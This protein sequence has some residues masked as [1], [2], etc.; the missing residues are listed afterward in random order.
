[1]N[2]AITKRRKGADGRR[3]VAKGERR[4]GD[5]GRGR[6]TAERTVGRN[7][8]VSGREGYRAAY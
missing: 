6:R 3:R 7:I 2:V 5:A 8:R 1:M 4:S